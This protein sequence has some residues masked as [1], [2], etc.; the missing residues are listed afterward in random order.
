M[1]AHRREIVN[2][3]AAKLAA[4]GVHHGVIQAGEFGL[5]DE[6]YERDYN[7]ENDFILCCNRRSRRPGKP[8]LRV[9]Y[10]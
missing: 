7:E 10:T 2:Q 6:T 1:V 8:G 3:T 5:L 4:F 9:P